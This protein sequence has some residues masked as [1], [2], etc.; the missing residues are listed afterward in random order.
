M[1][2]EDNARQGFFEHSDF[3]KLVATLPEPINDKHRCSSVNNVTSGTDQ[4]EALK[5]TA[6]HLAALPKSDEKPVLEMPQAAGGK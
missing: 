3:E 5:K 1:M 2:R 4:V 6:A